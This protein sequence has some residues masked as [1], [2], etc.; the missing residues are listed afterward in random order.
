VSKSTEQRRHQQLALQTASW[1]SWAVGNWFSNGF[2]AVELMHPFQGK[3]MRLDFDC[4]CDTFNNHQHRHHLDRLCVFMA[5]YEPDA[6]IAEGLSKVLV[7]M[8]GDRRFT[9]LDIEDDCIVESLNEP[10]LEIYRARINQ[11]PAERAWVGVNVRFVDVI[12]QEAQ[13]DR[14]FIRYPAGL[15]VG[16]QIVAQQMPSVLAMRGDRVVAAVV[17]M[18]CTGSAISIASEDGT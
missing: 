12:R 17:P 8:I 3:P 16:T 18:A 9:R 4:L 6:A 14:W 11:D 5:A 13:P 10:G 15:P 1:R 2:M 7:R